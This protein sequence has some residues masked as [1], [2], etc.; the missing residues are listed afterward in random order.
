M[1]KRRPQRA[2]E[3]GPMPR[4]PVVLSDF[5]LNFRTNRCKK[6]DRQLRQC[7][8]PNPDPYAM[9]EFHF[10]GVLTLPVHHPDHPQYP[11]KL[12]LAA[13]PHSVRLT[14]DIYI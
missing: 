1:S 12:C 13:V 11:R 8:C 14:L 4:P 2:R 3:S 7:D 9:Q 5:H 6:C 10:Q